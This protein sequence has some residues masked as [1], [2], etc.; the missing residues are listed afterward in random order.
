[1]R[2]NDLIYIAEKG[3]GAPRPGMQ[4]HASTQRFGKTFA[5]ILGGARELWIDG[6]SSIDFLKIFEIPDSD[7]RKKR[8]IGVEATLGIVRDPALTGELAEKLLEAMDLEALVEQ[9]LRSALTA[10]FQQISAQDRASDPVFPGREKCRLSSAD[11]LTA[12]GLRIESKC[13]VWITPYVAKTRAEIELGGLEVTPIDGAGRQAVDL[14][15]TLEAPKAQPPSE[16]LLTWMLN[17]TKVEEGDVSIRQAVISEVRRLIDNNYSTQELKREPARIAS[18]V[19]ASLDP[20]IGNQ[21]GFHAKVHIFEKRGTSEVLRYA[22][23]HEITAPLLGTGRRVTFDIE[24]TMEVLEDDRFEDA[25]EADRLSAQQ[26]NI[27][28]K[29]LTVAEH[30]ST[31]GSLENWAHELINTI[32]ETELKTALSRIDTDKLP[33][34]GLLPEDSKLN[35]DDQI[36]QLI[37]PVCRP[38]GF[39][40]N[41][42]T[43]AMVD[44]RLHELKT[45][46]AIDTGDRDYDLASSSISPKLRF[47]YDAYLPDNG[48]TKL[49]TPY[50]QAGDGEFD[51]FSNLRQ[52][53]ADRTQK[54]AAMALG[55]LSPDDYLN[56]TGD[57]EAIRKLVLGN[58]NTTLFKEF[59]LELREPLVITTAPDKVQMRYIEMRSE[60]RLVEIPLRVKSD[61]SGEIA[62][63]ML[64]LR[65][66]VDGVARPD[67]NELNQIEGT[68]ESWERFRTMAMNFKTL[69][70]HLAAFEGVMIDAVRARLESVP[71]EAFDKTTVAPLRPQI[72]ET[73]EGA[74]AYFGLRVR[75]FTDTVNVD[76]QNEISLGGQ[77]RLERSRRRVIRL[78][79]MLDEAEERLDQI[80]YQDREPS[81]FRDLLG[82]DDEFDVDAEKLKLKQRIEGLENDLQD[83]QRQFQ[84]EKA[85]ARI[86]YQAPESPDDES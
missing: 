32:V 60:M 79:R 66:Q 30:A 52:T 6:N 43:S 57:A 59:G 31:T 29:V 36:N 38:L 58:L 8:R 51:P 33:Q 71:A 85:T 56:K 83:A 18:E 21:F 27:G 2:L 70:D 53:V 77:T 44:Q 76:F 81:K 55:Q 17:K 74:G 69:D 61:Y 50:L 65:Y 62:E 49:L 5:R 15:V 72:R 9:A 19:T 39:Q 16:R 64:R 47:Q 35:L 40:A 84:S 22:G 20:S 68:I 28:N 48:Q 78:E 10:H 45:G 3:E 24:Y 4:K 63:L 80:R 41:V 86:A 12:L 14:I 26:K 37:A 13:Q 23:A 1:M 73:F 25:F 42:R 82:D 46:L 75:V 54:V 7:S 11:R 34:F 67:P